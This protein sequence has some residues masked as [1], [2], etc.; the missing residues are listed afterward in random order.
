MVTIRYV[1]AGAC[2]IV[3]SLAL[4]VNPWFLSACL[5]ASV[6]VS[7]ALR[8]PCLLACLPA[9]LPR[10]VCDSPHQS[11]A[12][13]R[14]CLGR[15]NHVVTPPLC[16]IMPGWPGVC[17]LRLCITDRQIQSSHTVALL[18]SHVTVCKCFTIQCLYN[19]L[20]I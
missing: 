5:N 1:C 8:Q 12:F 3:L 11:V 15:V 2:V 4:S 19:A 14:L 9:C 20:V 7:S 13:V 6:I 10:V 18:A 16:N 17:L